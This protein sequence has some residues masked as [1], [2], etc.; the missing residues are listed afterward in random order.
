MR[1]L[2]SFSVRPAL[3]PEL[4]P[5][6]RLAM[7]LRWSWDEPTRD[8]FRWVDT[9]AW[10]A[11]SHDPVR[12]L[13]QVPP[14]RLHTSPP[15]PA[16]CATSARPR[17]PRPLPHRAPLVPDQGTTSRPARCAWSP[18]SPPSSASPKRCRST[19]GGLGVLAG[20]HLKAIERPRRAAGRRRA[21]LPLRLLQPAPGPRRHAAGALLRARPRRAG[22]DPVRGRSGHRRPRRRAP[23]GPGLAGRR[24]AGSAC[25]SSTPTSTATRPEAAR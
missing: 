8:L 18:T 21:V 14:E 16:S 15:T 19:P 5:L 2:Q 22:A 11:M 20:D 4:S 9:D 6:E 13:G 3:P 24:R 7:N 25:T 10:E 12:L 23:A 1:S 17:R